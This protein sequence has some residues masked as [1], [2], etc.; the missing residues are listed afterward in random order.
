MSGDINGI[1][2]TPTQMSLQFLFNVGQKTP[3][4]Q[5]FALK[6]EEAPVLY[7]VEIPQNQ[8]LCAFPLRVLMRLFPQSCLRNAI[9]LALRTLIH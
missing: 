3:R 8:F 5:C 2:R 4:L 7:S 6:L 1:M 9:N